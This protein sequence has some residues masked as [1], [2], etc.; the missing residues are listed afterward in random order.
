MEQTTRQNYDTLKAVIESLS[1]DFDKF[2][3]K[4]VKIA[5]QRVRNNLLNAKKLCDKMRK[6]IIT[7]MK[8]LPTK[9]R[10]D[11]D[12]PPPSPEDTPVDTPVESLDSDEGKEPTEREMMEVVGELPPVISKKA[13]KPKKEKKITVA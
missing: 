2:E 11:Y 12:V 8:E 6:Q 3:S 1:Q 10:E 13:K 4:K 5:G 7:E 9:H